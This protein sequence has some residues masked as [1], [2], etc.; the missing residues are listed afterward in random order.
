MALK[1]LLMVLGPA[2]TPAV[3]LAGYWAHR[4]RTMSLLS[5]GLGLTL[6]LIAI[7]SL[8]L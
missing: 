2:L 3:L 5:L 1:E 8:I 6:L 7:F 4:S